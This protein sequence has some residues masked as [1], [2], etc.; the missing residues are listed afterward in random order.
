MTVLERLLQPVWEVSS[1][2][3]IITSNEPDPKDRKI[4]YVNQAFSQVNGYTKEEAIGR[5]LTL[6]H[7][8]ETDPAILRKSEQQLREGRSQ[9][10]ALLHYRKDG[11]S[12]QCIVTRAPLVDA[13]GKSEYLISIWR[14]LPEDKPA[15]GDKVWQAGS[16]PL[17]I[18]MPLHE[19]RPGHHPRHL[20]SHPELD[21]LKELWI[22]VC[23]ERALPSRRDFDLGVMKGWAPHV[24]I[25]VVTPEGRFQFRLFG[26][27]LAKVYGRDLTGCFL[28]ELTPNDLWLVVILHYQEVVRTRQPLFAPISISN[29]RWYTEVSRLLLPLSTD[30]HVNFIMS[31]DYKRDHL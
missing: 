19:L 22:E 1:E 20:Q 5:P 24:S 17:T 12:Y 10:Y 7:G 3:I 28:D 31:A 18:P 9:E 29:G 30:S 25:A 15:V 16:V 2:P 14:A 6:I 23:G 21:A 27:E 13:D 4:L 11:S 26:T 8:P